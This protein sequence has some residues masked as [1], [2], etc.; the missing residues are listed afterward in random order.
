M[1]AIDRDRE[2]SARQRADWTERHE[3][4]ARDAQR[5]IRLFDGQIVNGQNE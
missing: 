3:R 5:T 1:T 2:I 4:Y